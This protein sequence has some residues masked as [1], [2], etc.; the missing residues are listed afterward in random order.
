MSQLRKYAGALLLA[1]ALPAA[2]AFAG[3]IQHVNVTDF[4]NP[5]DGT[6]DTIVT[7]PLLWDEIDYSDGLQIHLYRAIP[8]GGFDSVLPGILNPLAHQL[9]QGLSVDDEINNGLRRAIEQWN[10][11]GFTDFQFKEQPLFSDQALIFD[12]VQ[13]PL[14]VLPPNAQLDRFSLITFR[15]TAFATLPTGVL[16]EP[17]IYYFNEDFD[18]D[19]FDVNFPGANDNL[20]G[21]IEIDD[22]LSDGTTIVPED[23]AVI[24]LRDRDLEFLLPRQEWDAGT[25]IDAD[26]IMNSAPNSQ[27]WYLLP[28]DEGDLG[29]LNPPFQRQDIIGAEDIQA[30]MTRALGEIAGLGGSHLYLSSMTPFYAGNLFDN[31][32]DIPNADQV[33]AGYLTDPYAFREIS[34]DDRLTLS[35]A[36]P[37]GDYDSAA[38]FGGSLIDGRTQDIDFDNGNPGELPAPANQIIYFGYPIPPDDP[39]T[40]DTIAANN[41]RA[42]WAGIE[43]EFVGRIR[44]VAHTVTGERQRTAAGI[45][46]DALDLDVNGRYQLRG[47]PSRDDWY[48]FAAPAEFAWDVPSLATLGSDAAAFPNE[49]FGGVANPTDQR[50]GEDP[51]TN[52]DDQNVLTIRNEW[53]VAT[54]GGVGTDDNAN[55][56]IDDNEL[57]TNGIFNAQVAGGPE[58]IAPTAA[59]LSFTS[60]RIV[61]QVSGA[62]FEFPNIGNGFGGQPAA[63][64]SSDDNIDVIVADFPLTDAVGNP[65]GILRQRLT[66]RAYPTFGNDSEKR[67]FEVE[68]EF[69]NTSTR[70]LAFGVAHMYQAGLGIPGNNGLAGVRIFVNGDPLQIATGYGLPGEDPVPVSVDWFDDVFSPFLQLSLFGNLTTSGLTLPNRLLVVNADIVREDLSRIWTIPPGGSI[71]G[72]VNGGGLNARKGVLL[73]W[74][75]QPVSPSASVSIT[76]GGTYI[77]DPL[78]LDPEVSAIRGVENGI[79][80]TELGELFADEA[81]LGFA[82]STLGNKY[83]DPIDII[84]NRGTRLLNLAEDSDLDGVP[85]VADN[86]PFVPNADQADADNDGIG[87][88]CEGDFDGDGV[89]DAEDNCPNTPNF[90][91]LDLDG[92]GIGDS[93]DPDIDQDGVPNTDDNCPFVVNPAQEDI[94][95]D[96]V[97]DICETDFDGD[98]V[99]D[100]FDNCPMTPNPSQSDLDGDGIGDACDSDIDGDGVPNGGDNCVDIANPDQADT[101]GDGIGDV[102]EAT[103]A[104]LLEKSPASVP[105]SVN[106]IPVAQ[107]PADDLVA[108]TVASGDI[109]GDGYNDLVIGVSGQSGTVNSGLTS[110]IYLNEGESNPGF[111]RDVT[112]GIDGRINTFDDRWRQPFAISQAVTNHIILF[113]FDLDGDLDIYECVGNGQN[114]LWL[115]IDIDDPAVNPLFDDDQLGD[116]FFRNSTQIGLPGIFNAKSTPQERVV[117]DITTRARV[118][119]IDADGDLDIIVSNYDAANT[120]DQVIEIP[121]PPPGPHGFTNK[122]GRF[123][124]RI[125]IN[126]RDELVMTDP[127]TGNV[128]GRI[129]RGTPD[130]FIAQLQFVNSQGDS[131]VYAERSPAVPNPDSYWFRDETFGRDN[132]INGVRS[133]PT[134]ADADRLPPLFNDFVPTPN[135]AAND[136]DFSNTR[137]VALGRHWLFGIGPDFIVGNE[138]PQLDV[139]LRSTTD[140]YDPVFANTDLLDANAIPDGVFYQ[141]NFSIEFWTILDILIGARD[142]TD[143]TYQIQGPPAITDD[144]PNTRTVTTGMTS[145]DLFNMGYADFMEVTQNVGTAGEQGIGPRILSPYQPDAPASADLGRSLRNE[146]FGGATSGFNPTNVLIGPFAATPL[147][148]I[149]AGSTSV[150]ANYEERMFDIVAPPAPFRFVGRTRAVDTA[151]ITRTGFPDVMT[152]SDAPQGSFLNTANVLGGLVGLLINSDGNGFRYNTDDEGA[153]FLHVGTSA[154][155]P[156]VP[157]N[158]SYIHA[159]DAD[160][161]ADYDIFVCNVAGQQRLYINQLYQPSLKP[162]ITASNDQPIFHDVTRAMIDDTIDIGIR[163]VGGISLPVFSSL[164][165]D[166]I[167]GD[168]NRDGGQDIA[169]I[170]GRALTSDGDIGEILTNRGL[171]KVAGTAVYTPASVAYPPGRT[172]SSGFTTPGGAP[173]IGLEQEPLPGA[174][175]KFF[176]FDQDGDLDLM[177]AYYSARNVLYEN[178]DAQALDLMVVGNPNLVGQAPEIFNSLFQYDDFELRDP[179]AW[180]AAQ[181]AEARLGDGVYEQRPDRLPQEILDE[182]RFTNDLAIGDADNDGDIDV[183][184]SNAAANNGVANA[185]FFNNSTKNPGESGYYSSRALEDESQLRLPK[186]PFTSAPDGVQEDDSISS[187]FFDADNDGDL[188]ILVANRRATGSVPNPD[189]KELS[190]LLINQGGAQ[191]GALGFFEASTTFP[192]ANPSTGQPILLASARIAVADFMRRADIAEDIDGNGIVE[193]MEILNFDNMVKALKDQESAGAGLFTNGVPVLDRAP[194]TYSIPVTHLGRDAQGRSRL[195][196]RAPRYVDMNENGSFDQVLD[197]IIVTDQGRDHY[198]RNQGLNAQNEPVF[199]VFTTDAYAVDTILPSTDIDVGDVD[200]DG[201]LDFVVSTST[202]NEAAA[203]AHLFANVPG[204]A[205]GRQ[206]LIA[207]DGSGESYEIPYTPSTGIAV[208]ENVP[209]S[210]SDVHGNGQAILLVDADNDG[211]L[212]LMVGEGGGTIG[213]DSIGA[214]NAFYENRVIGAGFVAQPKDPILRVPSNGTTPDPGL[215]SVKSLSPRSATKGQHATIRIYGS[216]FRNGAQVSFGGDIPVMYQPIVRS[217]NVIDVTVDLSQANLGPRAIRVINPNGGAAISRN[218]AFSVVLPAPPGSDV[219]DWSLYQ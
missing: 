2:T 106:G 18:P 31:L 22:T 8:G 48:I 136:T 54:I 33:A 89:P 194:G 208:R 21:A 164:T 210:A 196:K 205:G 53:A 219:P 146:G 211:D 71:E 95:Q 193:D 157:I 6:D 214:L 166:L 213:I 206:F 180:P 162:N 195:T 37:S 114:Q 39:V 218:D 159:F 198:F 122:T 96:G 9:Q 30:V 5:S 151:D 7:A 44:V 190:Q 98:G 77:V 202:D 110:R 126:R 181:L 173:K 82:L 187:V 153:S 188:D 74:N 169:V 118:A 117:P 200:L 24:R 123:S 149:I 87:D 70:D 101:D 139:G 41:P 61:D 165:S 182:Y 68:W 137:E 134:A 60:V 179:L 90:D 4:N 72:D 52:F 138:R 65:L 29:L 19:D 127:N 99:P 84:T 135:P 144:Y 56:I 79:P 51:V 57:S 85:D 186:V 197:F 67:G 207:A 130:A 12:P 38:G 92:D 32:P 17:I 170:N 143:P 25:V 47:L 59:Q 120:S 23:I 107:L 109:N 26:I 100:E 91:Q 174:H 124:E 63:A 73:R 141:P 104:L 11:S 201:W 1:A 147:V 175:G 112:F 69:E 163:S 203:S 16:Y 133:A 183:F 178:R 14:G 145:V 185:I 125:L 142:G 204:G 160:N 55:G 217:A 128:I 115:N 40:L 3:S 171:S 62:I 116:G 86:C 46:S 140:G 34:L 161:D 184:F 80:Q 121:G 192:P 45:N 97:G 156:N 76:N 215:I 58:Y 83:L 27:G 20:V 43:E 50:F 168:T 36:Y 102:C 152:V 105:I 172:I 176:D 209:S 88:V 154:L 113:D 131:P 75:P 15:D 42:Q 132:I 66:L 94:D 119:D 49:F 167:A 10:G 129:P 35:R 64:L 103:I 28:E 150:Y 93:C 177:V 216:E 199:S 78:V 108:S 191:G 148:G 111:F 155:R 212:D 189:F 81:D 158:G 13:F